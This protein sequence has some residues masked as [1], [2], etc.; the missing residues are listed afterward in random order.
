[1]VFSVIYYMNETSSPLENNVERN[2]INFEVKKLE[3]PKPKKKIKKVTRA[4]PKS[5][6]PKLAPLRGL[7]SSIAGVDFGMPTF[8]MN[9][10]MDINDS[11]LGDMSN[12]VMTDDTVDVAP[13]PAQRTVMTYPSRARKK[14]IT[15]YVV[16]NLLIDQTG[17]I[18]NVKLLESSPPGIFDDVAIEG[19]HSWKFEPAVYQG[20]KVQVWAKQKIRFDLG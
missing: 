13:K 15:G 19:V 6:Q 9:S 4:K 3:K 12:V 20:K 8:E 11:I 17:K 7:N 5:S 14:G 16:L 10:D 1:M 2:Q 18:Q